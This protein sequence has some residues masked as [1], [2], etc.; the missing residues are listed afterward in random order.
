MGWFSSNLDI[1]IQHSI[2]EVSRTW[3][4]KRVSSNPHEAPSS[5]VLAQLLPRSLRRAY[6]GVADFAGDR[7]PCV[8]LIH[9]VTSRKRLVAL[10]TYVGVDIPQMCKLFFNFYTGYH[11]LTRCKLPC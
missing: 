10:L 3:F 6:C 11:G 1:E 9:M 8:S 2:V 5:G 4:I 7:P